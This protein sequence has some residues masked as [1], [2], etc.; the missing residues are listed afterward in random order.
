MADEEN[1]H[2]E[3]ELHHLL[4]NHSSRMSDAGGA[5]LMNCK[6]P[7]RHSTVAKNVGLADTGHAMTRHKP[8]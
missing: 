8:I 6:A 3:V 1:G 5:C 2:L 7:G 4:Q